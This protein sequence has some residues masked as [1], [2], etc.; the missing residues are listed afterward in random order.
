MVRNLLLILLLFPIVTMAQQGPFS[1]QFDLPGSDAVHKDS[2]IIRF[3]AINCQVNRGFRRIDMPDSGLVSS[4]VELN[5]VGKSDAPS[6]VSLGDGGEAIVTFMGGINNGEGPDFVVFENGF[7]M[8]ESAFL[9]LAFVE[10][11]SDGVNYFRFPSLTTQDTLNQLEGFEYTDASHYH[12]LAG[13]YTVGY[14]VPFDLSVLPDTVLLD[15]SNITHIK[16]IDVVGSVDPNYCSRD[17][18]GKIIND[19]WP[20]SFEQGGF[21]LDAVGVIHSTIPLG[22]I[23]LKDALPQG[24][25]SYDI[26]GRPVNNGGIV[27]QKSSN[28]IWQKVYRAQ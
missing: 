18:E 3:W 27:I 9:E 1:P 17:S 14:G 12:N 11:S 16:I 6:V 21:D 19:P 10:A 7:G 20:T 15:K 13:K 24:N 2:S 25:Q 23:E 26:L 5:A 4:G 22:V 28:G 8:G